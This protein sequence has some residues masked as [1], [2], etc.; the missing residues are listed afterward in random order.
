MG[1]PWTQSMLSRDV[2]AATQLAE[3]SWRRENTLK[4]ILRS[5]RTDKTH[6]PNKW[7]HIL[8][9]S[10]CILN[11]DLKQTRKEWVG[12]LWWLWRK[13]L[14]CSQSGR[15]WWCTTLHPA[16]HT[17]F[18]NSSACSAACPAA[19]HGP[20]KYSPSLVVGLNVATSS[21]ELS[22]S[23]ESKLGR[24]LFFWNLQR[25][26]LIITFFCISYNFGAW[27]IIKHKICRPKIR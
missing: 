6:S 19:L 18:T 25:H 5:E 26:T 22:S 20:A 15:E 23:L 17:F 7:V 2:N 4:S 14:S 24:L 16:A 1:V 12:G 8:P 3:A 11:I 9:V 27:N 21:S 10:V 13:S